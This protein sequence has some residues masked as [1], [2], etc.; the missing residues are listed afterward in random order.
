MAEARTT[1]SLPVA[2][3][4]ELAAA[5]NDGGVERQVPERYLSKDPSAE[6]VVVAGGGG[7]DS[8]CAIPVIDLRRLI[9]PRSEEEECAKLASACHHW[10][11]FQLINHGVPD[12]VIGNLMSD[13]AGF[14]KQPLEAK[15]ECSQK[16]DS[17]EGYGQAFVV[18]DDQKLDW[19]DMLY[20]QVQP[21]ESRDMRFWPTRP[22]SFRQSVDAYSS[23]AAKLAYRLL[24]FMAKG[25][26]AEPASLRGVFEG[27][28][29]GMRVNYYPPCRQA[30]DRVLGLTAHTDPN[31]LTL[32]LQM[33]DDVQGL[34]VKKDGKWFA[35]QAL[36]GA[37][38]VNVGDALEIM[39]NGV[40]RSVEHRAVI[41]PTKERI[42]VA[43][44]HYPYQDRM[45]GPLPELVKKGDRLQY[46]PTDYQDLLKRYFT[47]KLDGRKHLE[48]FMLEQ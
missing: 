36:A 40:F 46:G 43:L 23:E 47:A 37:F 30:A 17:L 27:Q 9:D 8:A 45:L 21:T 2:N 31:G 42:S 3:V 7:D 18:S 20:L 12:E 25:V 41:H 15:K 48:R 10:G 38:I 4:Q 13:V 11:F 5:F 19:A 34:Q 28:A 22:A 39:S 24:E 33:N 14:F 1:G 16:A 6:E 29:Q 32:L 26:G 35:V 44:F